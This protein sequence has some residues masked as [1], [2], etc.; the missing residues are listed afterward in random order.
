MRPLFFLSLLFLGIVPSVFAQKPVTIAQLEQLLTA[1]HDDSDVKRAERL[2]GLQLTE[3]ASVARLAQWKADFPGKRT[4]EALIELADASS[5]LD[6]PAEEIS[7][8]APPNRDTEREML[9][10]VIEYAAKVIPTLPNFIATRET[11][12]FEDSPSVPRVE[13]SGAGAG[14]NYHTMRT[15]NFSTGTTKYEP[16]HVTGRSSFPV[17]Y[18]DGKEVDDLAK[19]KA[20]R[21][22]TVAMGLTTTGEF[23]PI[24]SVVLNDAF[25]NHMEWGH[26]EQGSGGLIAVYRYAVPQEKS[27]YLVEFLTGS[28]W[29]HL[30][31]AY[32]GEIAI[33][34]A[35]G[36]V[37]RLTVVTELAQP[38]QMISIANRVDYGPVP[39]GDRTY[40]C[41]LKG[42]AFSTLPA[43]FTTW[44]AT[45]LA[46]PA[47]LQTR[48]NDVTFTNY[49]R[50]R[51]DVRILGS[52][53]EKI[54]P[55]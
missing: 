18:R 9:S 52:N 47:A 6:L 30:N 10:R 42:V 40:I 8:N 39:I 46:P 31:P 25:R 36:S 53:D 35:T 33:D 51:A 20:A 27:H 21:R 16:L 49:H 48:L 37:L 23:G 24:L 11:I 26:W 55:Q 7:A 1:N 54:P 19:G 28:D 3:R 4:D 50:F 41:P 12:H 13:A 44:D 2:A 5:F 14:S 22:E 32:R 29:T 34:P 43:A 17:T 45:G 38:F 15:E